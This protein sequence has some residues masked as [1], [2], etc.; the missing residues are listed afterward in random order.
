MS[1]NESNTAGGIHGLLLKLHESLSGED[2]RAAAL[3]SHDIFIDLGQEC[4][5]TP[6]ENELGESIKQCAG[7][8]RILAKLLEQSDN[9]MFQMSMLRGGVLPHVGYTA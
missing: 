7:T 6:T 8:H 9:F 2:R 3:T 1:S 5:V 4:M